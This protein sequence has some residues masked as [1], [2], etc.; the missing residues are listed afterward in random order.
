[1]QFEVRCCGIFA[2]LLLL[3][4]LAGTIAHAS[5]DELNP[6]ARTCPMLLSV[7][8]VEDYVKAVSQTEI[9]PAALKR[10]ETKMMESFG[11]LP[12][13]RKHAR[14][15]KFVTILRLT[16][17]QFTGAISAYVRGQNEKSDEFVAKILS[18]LNIVG[19]EATYH[20]VRSSVVELGDDPEIYRATAMAEFILQ[21][22]PSVEKLFALIHDGELIGGPLGLHF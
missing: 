21:K 15:Q 19:A 7:V 12:W 2:P 18:G 9:T 14:N 17:T 1:M 13:V 4:S 3:M 16:F 6:F 10:A 11:G 22:A 20:D 8:R 5:E